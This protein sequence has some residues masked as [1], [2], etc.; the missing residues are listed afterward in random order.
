MSGVASLAARHPLLRVLRKPDEAA[1]FATGE[2]EDLIWHARKTRLGGRVWHLLVGTG[3]SERLPVPVRRQLSSAFI[4][5]EAHRRG[6]L[7]EL[8]RLHRILGS[9]HSFVAL[10]GG[11]Y[12]A[13]GLDVARGRPAGDIDVMV[14]RE[15]IAKVEALLLANGWK[16]LVEEEYDQRYYRRWMHE[17]PP[18]VHALRRTELDLHH[19]ILPLSSRLRP[20]A[21]SLYRRAITVDAEGTKVFAPADMVLHGAVHLFHDGEIRGALRDLVDIDALIR[22]FAQRPNFWPSLVPRARELGLERPLFYALRYATQLLGTPVPAPCMADAEAGRSAAPVL[23]IMDWAVIHAI[24]PPLSPAEKR[25]A[26]CA[27][28]LLYIRSHYLRMSVA[29]L[30]QHLARKSLRRLWPGQSRMRDA[31]P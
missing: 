14:P 7:W 13:A 28:L 19:A 9:A 23:A 3:V 12:A 26:R 18:L 17:I 27:G 30:S 11:A 29:L 15:A 4:A 21:E 22:E 10:K 31:E 20:D 25:S 5:G 2:W 1:R 16:H 6:L 8:D 24:V